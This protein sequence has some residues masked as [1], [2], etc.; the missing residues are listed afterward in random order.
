MLWTLF[1][2][3]PNYILGHALLSMHKHNDVLFVTIL[4]LILN[5]VINYYLIQSFGLLG[6]AYAALISALFPFIG[7]ILCLRNKIKTDDIQITLLKSLFITTIIII[8]GL[9]LQNIIAIIPLVMLLFFIYLISN[10][11]LKT[12]DSN[13]FIRIKELIK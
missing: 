12:L 1:A 11:L 6:A 8:I 4:N 2:Y 13:D 3:F 5:I 7:Y 10:I 9:L